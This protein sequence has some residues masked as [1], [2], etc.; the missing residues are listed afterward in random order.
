MDYYK[1]LWLHKGLPNFVPSLDAESRRQ[2]KGIYQGRRSAMVTHRSRLLL[3]SQ[4]R[5]QTEP[6]LTKNVVGPP[7]R[8]M[9]GQEMT[10]RTQGA[11]RHWLSSHCTRSRQVDAFCLKFLSFGILKNTSLQWFYFQHMHWHKTSTNNFLSVALK[12]EPHHQC[13][14]L[15]GARTSRVYEKQNWK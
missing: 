5:L 14:G 10:T 7:Q 15:Y 13:Y 3:A 11:L 6:R 2:A 12:L 1:Y 4:C 8:A 9:A